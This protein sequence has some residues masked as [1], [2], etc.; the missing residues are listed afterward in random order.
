MQALVIELALD[1]HLNTNKFQLLSAERTS[2]CRTELDALHNKL[3]VQYSILN[4]AGDMSGASKRS[5]IIPPGHNIKGT[6]IAHLHE[7]KGSVT[8]LTALSSTMSLFASASTDGTV[9]LFD[10]NKL[11]GYQSINK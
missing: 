10:C 11:N 3:K 4:A 9:R 7:H 6:L 8:K 1:H 2:D 5:S